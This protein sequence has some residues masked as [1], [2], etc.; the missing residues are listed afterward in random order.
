MSRSNPAEIVLSC[1]SPAFTFAADEKKAPTFS[2]V[3]Y[4]GAAMQVRSWMDPVIVDMA[5]IRIPTQR[6]PIRRDHSSDR[7]VGHTESVEVKGGNLLATGVI[8]FSNGNARD[9]VS[10]AKQGFPWQASIGASADQVEFLAAGK[11]AVVNGREI[12]GPMDILRASTLKEISFVD[13]GADG[14]TSATVAAQRAKEGNMTATATQ[15][16]ESPASPTTTPAPATPPAPAPAP[17]AP[18]A[19]PAVQA[20]ARGTAEDVLRSVQAEQQRSSSVA[21]LI[22][23]ALERNPLLAGETDMAVLASRAEKDRLSPQ[24]VELE[25]SRLSERVALQAARP[26]APAVHVQAGGTPTNAVLSA[27]LLIQCGMSEDKLAKDRDFGVTDA[28]RDAT[29]SAALKYKTLG[30]HGHI[31]LALQA[32]GSRKVPHGGSG[33]FDAMV[34]HVAERG[35]IR[36]GFSNVDLPGILGTAGNKLLLDAFLASGAT[37]ARI[38]KLS[39]FNNFLLYT[40]Y[41]LDHTGEFAKVGSTGEL[42]SGKLSQTSST[43]QLETRGQI[44]TLSRQQIINDDLGALADVPRSLG[45]K[46]A[47]SVERATYDALLESVDSFFDATIHKNKQTS[48]A[49]S[50]TSLGS[51]EALMA[52][53]LGADSEPIYAMPR[54]LL[55]P[56]GLKYLA[57]TLFSSAMVIGGSSLVPEENPWRGR[58]EP[59]SSPYLALAALDGAHASTWYLLADPNLLPALQVAFLQGRRQPTI[60]TADARFDTLGIQMR[61]YFDF[62]VAQVDYRGAVKS[63]A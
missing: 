33:L 29:V 19:T 41:R 26:G 12:T 4:T 46:A 62:G 55:V 35:S 49:L 5:G 10:S 51:A 9:V 50:I 14:A 47:L 52:S 8:S 37:Y 7:L 30:L 11:T 38:A 16:G 6:L 53:Q 42:K 48:S 32:N 3:A 34:E 39:D 40:N 61:C 31:G 56:P 27:A 21:V 59:V 44:M 22:Q 20:A 24:A 45:R 58:F 15:G 2:M 13:L 36:A 17:A 23:A 54:I 18:P 57:E 60:E 28:Q 1:E 43:N 25:L 63:V